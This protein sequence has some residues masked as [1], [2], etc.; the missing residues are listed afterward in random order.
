[1]FRFAK[2][3]TQF[4]WQSRETGLSRIAVPDGYST[5]YSL[6]IVVKSWQ[7]ILENVVFILK[8]MCSALLESVNSYC[9]RV[10]TIGNI[11][12]IDKL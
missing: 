7:R 9:L 11:T 4:K 3:L 5:E 10:Y 2:S 12:N 6:V 8:L 1:M